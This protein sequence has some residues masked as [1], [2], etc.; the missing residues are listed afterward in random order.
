L[1]D[2]KKAAAL[3]NRWANR[4]K[5]KNEVYEYEL[6]AFNRFLLAARDVDSL[7]FCAYELDGELVG[8]V[9]A[10]KLGNG[11]A[12]GHFLK[13][14]PDVFGIYYHL[15]KAICLQLHEEKIDF[16]NIEQDLG[17]PG[18]REAKMHLR[19]VNFLKKFTL[20]IDVGY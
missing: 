5:L 7:R 9:A 6:Y 19:P 1:Q 2:I 3:A 17:N 20:E 13:Y 8:L 4:K 18:L 15:V 10:E 14:D 12:I 16:I 11:Y